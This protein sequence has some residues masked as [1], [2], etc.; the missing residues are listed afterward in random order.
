MSPYVAKETS[1][2]IKDIEIGRFSRWAQCNHNGPCKRG[3]G[4]S[5]DVK[6]E[7]EMKRTEI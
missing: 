1:D 3:P 4:E 2:I 5:E 7:A 6:M